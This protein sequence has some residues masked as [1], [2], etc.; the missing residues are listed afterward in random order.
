MVT[1]SEILSITY[2]QAPRTIDFDRVLVESIHLN[3]SSTPV[4]AQLIVT[5]LV[6]NEDIVS[7]KKRL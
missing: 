3:Y 6:L 5:C 2:R 1:F 7:N 4:P